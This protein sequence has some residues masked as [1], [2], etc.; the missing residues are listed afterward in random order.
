MKKLFLFILIS[1]VYGNILAQD[2]VNITGKSFDSS[3][4]ANDDTLTRSD[5]LLGIGKVFQILNKAPSVGQFAA[6]IKAIIQDMDEDD[7]ALN[8]IR[9]RL[10]VTDRT[11]NIRNLQMFN[12][13]LDHLSADNKRYNKKLTHYDSILDATKKEIFLIR[14]DSLMQDIFRSAALMETF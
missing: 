11:P 12:L 5:Y 4:F 2:T 6:P 1:F 14:K 7:S 13:L 10:S 9:E 8:I 3:A